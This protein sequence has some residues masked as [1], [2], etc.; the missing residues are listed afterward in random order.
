MEAWKSGRLRGPL[1]HP[2]PSQVPQHSQVPPRCGMSPIKGIVYALGIYFERLITHP[3]SHYWSSLSEAVRESSLDK[4]LWVSCP[5][6][7]MSPFEAGLGGPRVP[8]GV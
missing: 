3:A 2:I 5:I 6:P 8:S 7:S 4:L 1:S